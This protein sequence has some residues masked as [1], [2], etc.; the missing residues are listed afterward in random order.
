MHPWTAAKEI[1]MNRLAKVLATGAGIA[2]A[3]YATYVASTWL[4]YGR[5]RK[6]RGEAA[7]SLLDSLR[8]SG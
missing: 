8:A 3:S 7:D 6:A 5:P 2:G 4:R 1:A